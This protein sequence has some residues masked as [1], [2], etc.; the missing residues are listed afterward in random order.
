MAPNWTQANS[1]ELLKTIQQ[2]SFNWTKISE[3]YPELDTYTIAKIVLQLPFKY[4]K[5]INKLSVKN[6]ENVFK[7]K[8]GPTQFDTINSNPLIEHVS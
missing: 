5:N 8:E 7:D 6:F 2:C 1:I 4:F 3:K